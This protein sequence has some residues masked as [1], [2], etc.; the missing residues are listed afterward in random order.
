MV[1][2]CLPSTSEMHC[3]A[4]TSGM[5]CVLLFS[6]WVFFSSLSVKNGHCSLVSFGMISL[7]IFCMCQIAFEWKVGFTVVEP[8]YLKILVNQKC[9]KY[10]GYTRRKLCF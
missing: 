5:S 9:I 8:Q 3:I 1:G 2:M 7:I 4:I 6:S 10:V